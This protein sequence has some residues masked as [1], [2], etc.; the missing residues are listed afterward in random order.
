MHP[1]S[2][3]KFWFL[4]I[5]CLSATTYAIDIQF[6]IV[7]PPGVNPTGDPSFQQTQNVLN[8]VES[9]YEDI[10]ED[11]WTVPIQVVFVDHPNVAGANRVAVPFGNT[12]RPTQNTSNPNQVYLGTQEFWFPLDDAIFGTFREQL[13]RDIPNRTIWN[14]CD[15]SNVEQDPP[16]I[17]PGNGRDYLGDVPAVFEENF[18]S[19]TA[20]EGITGYDMFSIV[21]HEVGHIL[22]ISGPRSTNSTYPINE[23]QVGGFDFDICVGANLAHLGTNSL[24]QPDIA[25]EVIG[26]REYPSATDI[27]AMAGFSQWNQ[28]D[29]RRKEYLGGDWNLPFAWIGGRA[30]DSDDISNL[31]NGAIGFLRQGNGVTGALHIR[32][33]HTSFQVESASLSANSLRVLSDATLELNDGVLRIG[34]LPQQVDLQ[35]Q[36]PMGAEFLIGARGSLVVESAS[37]LELTADVS[38]AATFSIAQNATRTGLSNNLHVSFVVQPGS[39][40]SAKTVEVDAPVV[41]AGIQLGSEPTSLGESDGNLSVTLE[42]D[43]VTD[44][45][46]ALAGF[47]LDYDSKAD[48]LSS[49]KLYFLDE[50]TYKP[51][52]PGDFDLDGDVDG[53]DVETWASNIGIGDSWSEGDVNGDRVVNFDDFNYFGQFLGSSVVPEP[54][55]L[56]LMLP[57]FCFVG[58]H[59]RR[60]T[61]KS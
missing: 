54:D 49:P 41:L 58:L 29:L 3:T 24:M 46:N 23:D 12:V 11:S 6:S 53:V 27:L 22:G 26:R 19:T 57:I 14:S 40:Q 16:T 15:Q 37:S 9:Y 4:S 43:I 17:F 5:L 2:L 55:G 36:I 28:V 39:G 56:A 13:F 45:L 38:S 51:L 10:F 34:S 47:R 8:A 50:G 21:A 33:D 30:P 20:V 31:R 59:F 52:T 25:A 48:F 32:E 42:K 35:G 44:E 7:A 1:K 18:S 61:M 60:R